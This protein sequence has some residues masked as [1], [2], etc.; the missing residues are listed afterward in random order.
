M[1]FTWVIQMC[2]NIF[3]LKMVLLVLTFHEQD[4]TKGCCRGLHLLELDAKLVFCP[5]H[6]FS[7]GP[8]KWKAILPTGRA[9]SWEVIFLTGQAGPANER[10]FL[11]RAGPG[12]QK[13][14]EFGPVR[15]RTWKIGPCRPLIWILFCALVKKLILNLPKTTQYVERWP[16]I[17]LPNLS[18]IDTS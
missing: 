1:K 7:N 8:G 18:L 6:D 12:R 9:G 3:A 15:A 16:I 17:Y 4:L 13:R 11:Q 5:A 2:K 14:N 10:W